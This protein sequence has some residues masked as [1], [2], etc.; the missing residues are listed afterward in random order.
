[1]RRTAGDADEN[2]HLAPARVRAALRALDVRPSREMGQNFLVD[3]TALAAIVAAGAP[4][5][6]ETIVEVGPGLGVLTW[7]LLRRSR[8]VIAVELDRRLAGWLRQAFVG[9]PLTVIEADV[10]RLT[11]AAMLA[12]ARLEATQ[13][14]RVIANLP[15]AITSPV[16]RHFLEAAHPP[17]SLSV[18]VQR[19]VAERIT[20]APGDLSVLAHAIQIHAAPRLAAVIPR[21][22]FV[23]VPAVESAVLVLQ[24]RA[25]PLV[26]AADQA[27][28]LRVIKAGFLHARKQLGNSLPAGLT[29]LGLPLAR[30]ALLAVLEAAQID[31]MRRA[32]T[33][34]IDEWRRIAD[35]LAPLTP[36][37]ARRSADGP[38]DDGPGLD[39]TAPAGDAADPGAPAGRR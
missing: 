20:A 14:Y 22:A 31:A 8:Q 11:P 1:M 4:D 30:P 17:Q 24:R 39:G 3:A 34:T 35:A 18:L 5:H 28:V 2:P 23:P 37:A 10:L 7:E 25:A 6:G 9:A 27:R 38:H 26:P 21:E 33:L 19:E 16:L 13:A 36:G 15:Y 32:E 29:A 12:A